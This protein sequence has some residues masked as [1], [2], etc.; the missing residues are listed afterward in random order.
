MKKILGSAAAIC[1]V[2]LAGWVWL[3]ADSLEA[4]QRRRVPSAG[5]VVA[6][7][8]D[9]ISREDWRS[10][11]RL[12]ARDAFIAADQ[13]ILVGRNDIIAA[14]QSL[15]D[16]FD[17]VNPQLIQ[18]TEFRDTVRVLYSMDNGWVVLPDGVETYVVENGLITRQTSHGLI[19]FTGPP[20]DQN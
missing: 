3:G 20:P 11:A 6:E 17:G 18:V 12:Y 9:A 2:V 4:Q 14:H 7:L 10:V 1:G 16:L 5:E 19:E 8:Q 15:N 13:G